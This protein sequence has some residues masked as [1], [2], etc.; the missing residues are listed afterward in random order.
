M[1]AW[2]RR[3]DHLVIVLGRGT[4]VLEG[5]ADELREAEVVSGSLMGIGA[6]DQPRLAWF[7]RYEKQYRERTFDGVWEIASLIGNVSQFQDDIRLHCHAVISDRNCN[8]GGG[9]LTAGVVGV[10]CEITVVSYADPL[11]R[12]MDPECAL[13]LLDLS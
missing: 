2:I 1:S 4:P 6:I 13:P 3:N 11:H 5:I 8:T 10:T 7:D 12:S 9:H